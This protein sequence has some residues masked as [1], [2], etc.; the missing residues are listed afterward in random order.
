M[1]WLFGSAANNAHT[2]QAALA[3]FERDALGLYSSTG[4]ITPDDRALLETV[5]RFAP[6]LAG[7]LDRRRLDFL[8]TKLLDCQWGW[9]AWR[10]AASRVPGSMLIQDWFWEKNERSLDRLWSRLLRQKRFDGFLGV[11]HGALTAVREARRLGKK[12][13]VIFMS[14]HHSFYEKWIEPE[15]EKFPELLSPAARRLSDLARVRDRRRD[16]EASL[17]D[18]VHANSELTRKTLVAAGVPAEKIFCVPLGAPPAAD[19]FRRTPGKKLRILYSGPVSMRKGAHHLLLAWRKLKARRGAEL[20]IYG[21]RLLPRQ[22]CEGLAGVFFHGNVPSDEL[23]AAY[24]G[25]L[26]LVFPT[27]ADGFGMVASEALAQGLPVITTP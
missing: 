19:D 16:E 7:K 23:R 1:K 20:H 17:A 15:Y 12:S 3:L 6:R 10:L 18:C 2:H 27:L 11:E 5:R 24:R 14:L 22:F 21:I 4:V 25:S 13:A 8:P 26:A 9:E